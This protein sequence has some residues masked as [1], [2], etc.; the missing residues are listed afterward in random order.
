MSARAP[1]AGR[2][3]LIGAPHDVRAAWLLVALAL[4]LYAV[5]YAAF[6]PRGVTNTDEGLY[7]EQA[8]LLVETGSF[9][10]EKIDPFSGERAPFVTGDYPVGMVALMAPFV[11]AFGW[12][13]AFFPS[14]LCLVIAVLA[15][16][17]WLHDERRSPAFALILLSYPAVLVGGRL[18][19]SDVARTASAALALWWFFR[20]LDRHKGYWLASGFLAGAALSLR[21]SAALPFIPLF[22]ATLLR[23]DRRWTWLL[24]GGLAGTGLHLLGN[25]LAFGDAFYVRGNNASPYVLDFAL[26]ERLPVYLL[27][28]LVFVPG[29]LLFALAYRGR[30]RPEIVATI[31]I[32][33]GFYL[34]Q[35]FGIKETSFTK[36]LVV[37]LRY[38]D[39]LLPV[40]AFA[41]AESAPRLLGG[42]LGRR[43]WWAR[44][45]SG[46]TGLWIAGVL[47]ACFVV[48][49]V[50]DHWTGSQVR[51]RD[52]IAEQVPVDAVLVINKAALRKFLDEL[53]RPYLTLNRDRVTREQLDALREKH[54][55]YAIALLDRSDS[56]YWQRDAAKNAA[57]LASL[58]DPEPVVDVRV[59][60][61]DRL[62]IWHIGAKPR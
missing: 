15:T 52:A 46:A 27:G 49:P 62:R 24:A 18:A 30:R 34:F 21:E 23:R 58:G 10:A 61:T 28:L 56:E 41:M 13:G 37:G 53:A 8:R 40:L 11:E 6:Y 1:L 42:W 22:A 20:G 55:G 35:A 17:R 2:L 9:R 39:P 45:A 59:T 44:I 26:H 48:H 51:I 29:G 3:G 43:G 7:L 38:F 47:A 31:L 50:F 14:F 60:S 33:V 32:Y 57:F 54:G 19:M 36:G 5:G 4:V 12:R 16:A 25:Q